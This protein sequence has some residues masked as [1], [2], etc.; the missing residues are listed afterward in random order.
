MLNKYYRIAEPSALNVLLKDDDVHGALK[1][2]VDPR[3]ALPPRPPRL[4]LPNEQLR[5][6]RRR[7]YTVTALVGLSG[8]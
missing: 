5:S 2:F 4:G 7:Q 1:S 8:F 6:L 3:T